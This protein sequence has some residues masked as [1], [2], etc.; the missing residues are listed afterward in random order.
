LLLDN[1]KGK[2]ENAGHSFVRIGYLT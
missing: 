2:M 1:D